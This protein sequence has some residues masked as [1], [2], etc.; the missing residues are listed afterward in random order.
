MADMKR[1]QFVLE[2]AAEFSREDATGIADRL[3]RGWSL[4]SQFGPA[5]WSFV[6]DRAP[7][8]IILTDGEHADGR[9]W[10]H[11]SVAHAKRMPSYDELQVLHRAVWPTGWAYQ[12][13]APP[14]DHVNIHRFAL[15]LWGL[16]VGEA[17]LPNFGEA[18]SI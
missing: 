17:V 15:H 9:T 11:A 10:R 12:C 4:H 14:S 18:G 2:D 13:F 6:H 16:R 5:G 8:T 3:G 1:R 7:M